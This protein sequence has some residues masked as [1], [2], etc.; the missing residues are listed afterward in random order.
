MMAVDTAPAV[1]SPRTAVKRASAPAARLPFY[2]LM[3]F[4]FVVLIA[5]QGLVPA[6]APL[7]LALVAVTVAALS[8]V[9]DRMSRGRRLTALEPE[10]VLY[11]FLYCLRI[12]YLPTSY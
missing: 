9:A 4:T 12:I 5:P 1:R 10:V 3:F 2:A 6:L 7:H 11:L 8:H